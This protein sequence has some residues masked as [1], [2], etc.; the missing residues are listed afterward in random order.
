MQIIGFE[1]CK[2]YATKANLLKALERFPD[3]W[4]YLICCTEEGRFTAI[5]QGASLGG[6]VAGAA[7]EGF[8]TI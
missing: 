4:R 6:N 2:S 7:R 3:E 1:S 5:F 8:M